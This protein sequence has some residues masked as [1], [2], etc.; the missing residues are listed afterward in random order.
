M[1]SKIKDRL[2]F[3]AVSTNVTFFVQ[4][5]HNQKF[6]CILE[7]NIS[8]ISGQSSPASSEQLLP[9][10]FGNFAAADLYHMNSKF[11]EALQNKHGDIKRMKSNNNN[12]YA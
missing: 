12:T 3:L 6:K 5:T 11:G 10:E 7:T 4:H 9:I 8:R 2:S 1:T